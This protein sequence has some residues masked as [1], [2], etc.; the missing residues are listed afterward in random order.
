LRLRFTAEI[1]PGVLQQ[2]GRRQSGVGQ[3][4]YIPRRSCHS[5]RR[6]ATLM[7]RAFKTPG[8]LVGAALQTIEKLI[9]GFETSVAG[10]Q[11]FPLQRLPKFHESGG[12][13]AR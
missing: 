9:H 13:R 8:D 10:E 7:R 2:A 5:A 6:S 12:G 3:G 1:V 11:A 4:L